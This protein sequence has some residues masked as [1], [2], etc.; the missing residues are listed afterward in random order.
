M[1]GKLQQGSLA[2]FDMVGDEIIK[3]SRQPE[4]PTGLR[5]LMI[6]RYVDGAELEDGLRQG[7]RI[8]VMT[9]RLPAERASVLTK[10][11]TS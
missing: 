6:E 3:A 5:M 9:G 7:S 8:D 4:L 2:W 1:S 10:R 11:R